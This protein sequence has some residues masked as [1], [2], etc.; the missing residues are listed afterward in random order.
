MDRIYK[1]DKITSHFFEMDF[2]IN[3]YDEKNVTYEMF[4]SFIK[5]ISTLNAYFT[6]KLKNENLK[7]LLIK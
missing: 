1:Y 2:S 4:N 3:D 5:I 7:K 6:I